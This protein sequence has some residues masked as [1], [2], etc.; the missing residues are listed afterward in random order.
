MFF[1]GL[2]LQ[3][4]ASA[5]DIQPIV[6]DMDNPEPCVPLILTRV[7]AVPDM[8]VHTYVLAKTRAFPKNW[9]HVAINERKIDWLNNASNYAKVATDAINEAAGHGFITEF[10]GSTAFLSNSV[11]VAGRWN[12]DQL[13]TIKDPA[14]FVAQLLQMGF[15]RD[16]T[17]Q[18]LLRKYIPMPKAL[19]DMGVTE[20]AFYNNLSQYQA[21]LGPFDPVMFVADLNERVVAP[22]QAAQEMFDKQPWV[23]RLYST[24][25]PDEMT[26]DPLFHLNPDLPAVSNI[27]KATGTGEC[28]TDGTVRNVKLTLASGGEPISIPGPIQFYGN[29]QPWNY[30]AAE[31]SAARIELVSAFGQ[32]AVYTRGQA[33]VADKYLDQEDPDTV[34]GRNIPIEGQPKPDSDSTCSFGR[35]AGSGA[36]ALLLVGLAL[37]LGR[38]RRA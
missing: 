3:Q 38:R 33:L 6:L 32:P 2:K 9:F 13:S 37:L 25:S 22:L 24:V 18:A 11:Y 21:Q 29:N 12:L 19:M 31:P 15:P 8:P 4:N 17:M 26:R 7:A 16:T 10:A 1:V 27:H 36:G 20:S 23:T 28:Q 30:A 5:G 34:R 35:G 14:A